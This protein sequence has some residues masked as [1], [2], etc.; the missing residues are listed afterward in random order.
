MSGN[1]ITFEGAPAFGG[2]T[3]SGQTLT[4]ANP[5]GQGATFGVSGAGAFN[6]SNGKLN[7][8]GMSNLSIFSGNYGGATLSGSLGSGGEIIEGTFTGTS[9]SSFSATDSLIANTDFSG[10]SFSSSG[11]SSATFTDS[12]LLGADFGGATVSD[13]LVFVGTSLVPYTST[14][15]SGATT[16]VNTSFAG[17]GADSQYPPTIQMQPSSENP[18]YLVDGV[19][20]SGAN[21]EGFSINGASVTGANFNNMK[22]TTSSWG[23]STFDNATT[24]DGAN[25][26]SPDFSGCTFNGSDFSQVNWENPTFN[27]SDAGPTKFVSTTFDATSFQS[28]GAYKA[29]FDGVVFD[30]A[31]FVGLSETSDADVAFVSGIM[32]NA[33][34]ATEGN[35]LI[36]FNTQYV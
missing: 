30:G 13:A 6:I 12:A 27:S 34:N 35:G 3:A 32:S 23:N 8:N 21:L 29:T 31:T 36:A 16:T 22:A 7:F 15:E 5:D 20:F 19:S 24:W 4:F 14:D 25:L 28:G 1:T 18:S 9:F 33:N 2:M 11:T 17:L 26:S 10:A